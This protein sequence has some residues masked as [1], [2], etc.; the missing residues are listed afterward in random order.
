MAHILKYSS[1]IGADLIGHEARG[2][3]RFDYWVHR[4]GFG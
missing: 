1:N 3:K 4:F 2:A